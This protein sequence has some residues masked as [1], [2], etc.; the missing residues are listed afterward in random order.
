M[1]GRTKGHTAPEVLL[2]GKGMLTLRGA[3]G[4]AGR[5]SPLPCRYVGSV[6]TS[7]DLSREAGNLEFL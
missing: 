3:K 2:G 6:F 7:L 1:Q 5:N 4:A